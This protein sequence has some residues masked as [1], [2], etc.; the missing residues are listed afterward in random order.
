M[1]RLVTI[2]GLSFSSRLG[3]LSGLTIDSEF[4][5]LK[6]IMTFTFKFK[7]MDE[8][9]LKTFKSTSGRIVWANSVLASVKKL[10][11]IVES[12]FEWNSG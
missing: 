7:S 6:I 5:S 12:S 9:T 8:D 11:L 1:K 4:A 3:I 2:S 10:G